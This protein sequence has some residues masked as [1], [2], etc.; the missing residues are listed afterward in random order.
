[1]VE[2]V[3]ETVE[4]YK[5][6]DGNLYDTLE[7]AEKADKE[8]ERKNSFDPAKEVALLEKLCGNSFSRL[9]KRIDSGKTQFPS[10]WVTEQKYGQV[11]YMCNSFDDKEEMGWSAFIMWYNYYMCGDDETVAVA[12]LIKE[13]E[14]KKAALQ[15][16][17]DRC[18]MG[19]EYEKMEEIHMTTFN[20]KEENTV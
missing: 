5:S 8:W 19:Y 6:K 2:K 7:K 15:F 14:N 13:T 12:K 1:M 4:K 9:Q 17:L 18:S 11:Y 16:V 10:F 20:K 3:T